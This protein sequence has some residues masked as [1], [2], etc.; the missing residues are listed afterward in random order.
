MLRQISLDPETRTHAIRTLGE[1]GDCA[2][3]PLLAAMLE[4]ETPLAR[5][6]IIGALADLRDPGAEPLLV[7]ALA[8]AEPEV[9]RSAVDALARFGTPTA[10]R[11]GLAAARDPEWQ[12]RAASVELLSITDDALSVGALERLC[13]DENAFVADAARRRLEQKR[14]L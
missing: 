7:R 8:D 4:R 11:H 14:P 9:R 10:M 5:I 3:A 1:L 12:V 13:F 6:A 2:V